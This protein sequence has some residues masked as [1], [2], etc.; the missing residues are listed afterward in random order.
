MLKDIKLMNGH[1]RWIVQLNQLLNNNSPKLNINP[2]ILYI[3]IRSEDIFKN[4][5]N[6]SYSQPP[7][8]LYKKLLN[9]FIFRKIFIITEDRNN[10]IINH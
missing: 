9:K 3:H 5:R 4:P 6:N 8:W 10:P 7:I 2:N 1:V